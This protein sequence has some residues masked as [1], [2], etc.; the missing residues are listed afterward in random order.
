M[1]ETTT[2]FI[3]GFIV[4]AIAISV[5]IFLCL[6]YYFYGEELKKQ[7]MIY[8]VTKDLEKAKQEKAKNE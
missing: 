7:L 5:L 4:G 8:A 6:V 3:V 2:A 1:I